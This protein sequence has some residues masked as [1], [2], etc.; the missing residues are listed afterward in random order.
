MQSAMAFLPEVV[1]TR[2]TVALPWLLDPKETALMEVMTV[3]T[4]PLVRLMETGVVGVPRPP[5]LVT[6]I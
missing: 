3:V 4:D 6:L 5:G 1:G 2:L